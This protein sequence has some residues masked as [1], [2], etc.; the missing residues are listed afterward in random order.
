MQKSLSISPSLFLSLF[1]FELLFM[2][3][4]HTLNT[5]SR[6]AFEVARFSAIIIVLELI[7]H[8]RKNRGMHLYWDTKKK[9]VENEKDRNILLVF[10]WRTRTSGPSRSSAMRCKLMIG[11][12][13]LLFVITN[14]TTYRQNYIFIL[15]LLSFSLCY[16][17]FF[18]SLMVYMCENSVYWKWQLYQEEK[19]YRNLLNNQLEDRTNSLHFAFI[20]CFYF[21]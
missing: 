1:L 18:F 13:S 5:R 12:F 4:E 19:I 21:I 11:S 17:L 7:H 8:T 20:N 9:E 15:R 10:S 2:T 3:T 16:A 14:S 6:L